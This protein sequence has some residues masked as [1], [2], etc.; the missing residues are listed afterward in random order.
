MHIEIDQSGHIEMTRDNTALALANGQRYAIL[1]PPKTARA[2][3]QELRRKGIK[4]PHM[5]IRLFSAA[6]FFLLKDHINEHM[7]V[8][9][10]VEYAGLNKEIQRQLLRL[11]RQDGIH[12]NADQIAFGYVGKKSPAHDLAI[13]TYRGKVKPDRVIGVEEMLRKL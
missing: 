13:A 2:C 12:I 3:V 6:L 8:V 4:A 1:I 10:D 7:A 5:Q 9:I 11:L